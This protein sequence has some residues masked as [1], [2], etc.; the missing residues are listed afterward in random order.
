MSLRPLTPRQT[1]NTTPQTGIVYMF[2][3]MQVLAVDIHVLI[4]VHAGCDHSGG[5]PTTY[6]EQRPN[7]KQHV[8]DQTSHR[9]VVLDT[10]A[11]N[12]SNISH[13]RRGK[14]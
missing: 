14:H 6:H 9:Y 12:D 3:C 2:I 10:R 11:L 4:I 5:I 13:R 1:T 8:D 7:A